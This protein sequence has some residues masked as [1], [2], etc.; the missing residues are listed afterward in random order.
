MASD[1]WRTIREE[2]SRSKIP[3]QW[4]NDKLGEWY[5]YWDDSY[6]MPADRVANY[7]FRPALELVEGGFWVSPSHSLENVELSDV[8]PILDVCQTHAT[9]YIGW[10]DEGDGM[11]EPLLLPWK[12]DTE[13][14]PQNVLKELGAHDQVVGHV[15]SFGSSI[16]RWDGDVPP[17]ERD[18]PRGAIQTCLDEYEA[19]LIFVAGS[20][21]LNPVPCFAVVRV[22]DDLVAGFIGGVVYT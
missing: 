3:V 20:D 12:S 10:G 14:T 18:G 17:E 6:G 21:K 16:F 5:C 8:Q 4:R 19:P 22:K 13:F 2:R 9:I 1:H 11:W 15:N 7:V